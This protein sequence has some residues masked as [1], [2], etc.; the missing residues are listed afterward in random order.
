MNNQHY[1]VFENLNM[2]MLLNLPTANEL[3][4]KIGSIIMRTTICRNIESTSAYRN[5]PYSDRLS[6]VSFV[7][8]VGIM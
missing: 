1:K 3:I 4:T 8:K 7:Q 6:P 5:R 2:K